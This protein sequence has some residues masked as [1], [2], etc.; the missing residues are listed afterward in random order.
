MWAQRVRRWMLPFW[1]VYAAVWIVSWGY[2][3]T[4]GGG[5][6]SPSE[7]FQL[8]ISGG[9]AALGLASAWLVR[10]EERPKD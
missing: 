4:L 6:R 3:L 8:V 7:G 10:R 1:I 9:L 2:L 5:L